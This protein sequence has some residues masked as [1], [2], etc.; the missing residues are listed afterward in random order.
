MYTKNINLTDPRRNAYALSNIFDDSYG[1]IDEIVEC[2]DINN[3]VDIVRR[4]S[5]RMTWKIIKDSED[6]TRLGYT[7]GLGNQYYLIVKKVKQSTID[8]ADVRTADLIA[9]LEARGYT[10]RKGR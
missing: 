9:E 6:S 1:M 3:L 5:K 4:Y 2:N 8:L 10:V 7:D